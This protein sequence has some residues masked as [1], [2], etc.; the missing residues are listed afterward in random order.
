MVKLYNII[1]GIYV[2]SYILIVSAS[3]C[4]RLFHTNPVSSAQIRCALLSMNLFLLILTLVIIES[5]EISEQGWSYLNSHKNKNDVM[6]LIMSTT[7]LILEFIEL[8]YQKK[9]DS[10]SHKKTLISSTDD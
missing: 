10:G 3:L 1:K 8:D 7:C 5:K 4:L 9:T 6:L 2:L